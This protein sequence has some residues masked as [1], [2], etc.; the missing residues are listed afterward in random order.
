VGVSVVVAVPQDLDEERSQQAARDLRAGDRS[1]VDGGG[2]GDRVADD[3][4][5]HEHTLGRQGLVD[6]RNLN[7]AIR[8][9]AL[10]QPNAGGE[11]A[12]VVQ[13]GLNPLDQ[14]FGEVPH[15]DPLRCLDPAIELAGNERQ[16]RRVPPHE[17]ID[18][19]PLDLDDHAS[20]VVQRRPVRLADR[21][22]G[23]RFAIEARERLLDRLR[24]LCAQ[25]VHD[26]LGRYSGYVRVQLRELV[27]HR[28]GEQVGARG[29][30][31]PELH[32]H[33]SRPLQDETDAT[34]KIRRA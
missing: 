32:E 10:A 28:L 11:L 4:I 22:G 9:E 34:G 15:T 2:V 8:A 3:L 6:E 21:G 33:A 31:L 14:L 16:N 30:D 26:L 20:A 29:R 12:T 5:H 23:Q 27:R 1:R 24:E 25:Y 7:G 19:G 17:L 18:S 13:L